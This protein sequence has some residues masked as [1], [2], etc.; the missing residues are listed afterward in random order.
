[1]LTIRHVTVV[2]LFAE[3]KIQKMR[4]YNGYYRRNEQ[5]KLI[6]M[7]V[8]LGKQQ[9]Y[10]PQENIQ[11]QQAMVV[12]PVAMMQCYG[13]YTHRQ[14]D[15]KIF[16]RYIVY[17]FNSKQWQAGKYQWQYGAMD[18]A[19]QRSCNTQCIPVDF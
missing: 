19:G 3:I 16:E 11:R 17:N 12:L 2:R 14:K 7:P 1:M 6:I 4:S 5:P 8:L 13:S 9:R 10:A 15:H 18:G